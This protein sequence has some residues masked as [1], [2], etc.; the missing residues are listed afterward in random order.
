MNHAS[1]LSRKTR[2]SATGRKRAFTLL[3]LVVALVVLGI[4]AALAIPTY[5]SVIT[6]TK[7]G[8]ANSTALSA[9]SDAVAIGAVSDSP[10]TA[11]TVGTALGETSGVS[12][13]SPPVDSNGVLTIQYTVTVGGTSIP[14]CVAIPDTVN[15]G[16]TICTDA[17][18]A[19][20]TT[21]VAS[22]FA[23]PTSVMVAEGASSF[24]FAVVTNPNPAINGSTGQNA[25]GTVTFTSGIT[26]L[27]TATVQPGGT[28][29][30]SFDP[31][32]FASGASVSYM[33][34]YSGDS[35]Y[36]MGGAVGSFN[37]YYQ[38][39]GVVTFAANGGYASTM[40]AEYE[41]AGITPLFNNTFTNGTKTF[42]GWNT[43]ANGSGTSYAQ[44]AIYPGSTNVT[45]Y[46][47]WS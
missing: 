30:C 21:T 44:G 11:G 19:A 8:V 2:Y 27:C 40:A 7:T 25:T 33:A 41:I 35:N 12:L 16:P 14:V 5:Q 43:A 1:R 37:N 42:L 24:S 28:G 36:G 38:S 34:T 10:A 23:A 20:T 31:T 13:S 39:A 17:V 22:T 4:L 18:A 29:Y 3:E 9:A 26:T 45:L 32:Q 47:Q 15:A 46:A 6:S